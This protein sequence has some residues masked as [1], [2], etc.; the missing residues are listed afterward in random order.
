MMCT[1][2]NNLYQTDTH[3]QASCLY[4]HTLFVQAILF[5]VHYISNVCGSHSTSMVHIWQCSRSALSKSHVP[6]VDGITRQSHYC[7]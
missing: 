4:L 2:K 5:S 7:Q 3:P 6:E 1:A